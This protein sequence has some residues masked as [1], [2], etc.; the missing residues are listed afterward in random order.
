[1]GSFTKKQWEKVDRHLA[2]N[3]KR[4]GL[5]K[6][7]NDSIVLASFNIRKLGDV[8]KRKRSME[9]LADFC[10]RCDLVAIQ[11]VQ[12]NLD[13]LN[14]LKDLLGKDYGMVSSD[15]TGGVVGKKGMTERLAFLF[16]WKVVQRTEVASDVSYDKSW[17]LDVLHR[18][19]K[20]INKALKDY[21][22][23]LKTWEAK[24]KKGKKPKLILPKFLV[25]MRTPLCVSFR[26]ASTGNGE[27]Y[28]FL[29]VNAHLLYGNK[30]KQK[31][32][33]KM[34][35]RA[36]VE[37]LYARAKQADRLYH[38]NLLLFG[39]LNLDL[40][41]TDKRRIEIEDYIKS[42]N[43]KLL[44]SRKPSRVNFPFINAHPDM[45]DKVFRTNAR[46]DQTYDQIALFAHDKRLPRVVQ[47]KKAGTTPGGYDYGMFNFVDLFAEAL[48]GKPMEQL[49]KARRTSLFEKFEHNVSDHM[50]IWIRLP[51]P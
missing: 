4:F 24:E 6:K 35:F 29:A 26:V 34:E 1:M 32:E 27:P 46:R 28:E 25:F 8:D 17:V 31:E 40:K 10:R 39:D 5:P 16:R 33:R 19:K 15:I 37:W 49:T 13:G 20:A 42:L 45:K 51:R 23:A 41:E 47:N 44:K 22:D 7:R 9:F 14:H 18:E 21:E 30:T 38:K 43:R 12:D 11:E 3:E 48:Y 2:A 36:L 50:P